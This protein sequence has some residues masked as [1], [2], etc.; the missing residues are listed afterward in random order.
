MPSVERRHAPER[1]GKLPKWRVQRK[2]ERVARGVV[3]F[4]QVCCL[5]APLVLFREEMFSATTL[6]CLWNVT[7]K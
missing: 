4:M 7:R 2:G 3:Q 1:D 5:T 6:Q